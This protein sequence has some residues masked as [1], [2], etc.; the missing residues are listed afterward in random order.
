MRRVTVCLAGTLLAVAGCSSGES[1]DAPRDT[2]DDTVSSDDM[3]DGTQDDSGSA[4]G[5]PSMSV[6]GTEPA[7]PQAGFTMLDTDCATASTVEAPVIRPVDVQLPP[8]WTVIGVSDGTSSGSV[9]VQQDGSERTFQ[10]GLAESRNANSTDEVLAAAF[11]GEFD[12]IATITW[13]AD[14][15]PVGFDGSNYV[16]VM[17]GLRIDGLAVGV[18]QQYVTA[19]FGDAGTGEIAAFDQTDVV[20]AFD[21]ISLDRCIADELAGALGVAEVVI[22]D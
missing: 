14:Q 17:P 18:V 1:T 9:R 2:V 12:E 16:A 11:P 21:S 5:G 15:Y 6:F 10:V 20:A 19:R 13:G 7:P 22:V 3:Q 8:S 4:A